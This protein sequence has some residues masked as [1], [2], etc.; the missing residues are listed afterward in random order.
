ME[1]NKRICL[2][3]NIGPHYR[4]PIFEAMDKAFDIDFYFGDHV[5]KPLKVFDYTVLKGFKSI[6]RNKYLRNFYWQKGSVGLVMKPYEYYILDGEPYCLSSWAI[7]LLAKLKR[8]KVIAWTH[9]FYGR[10]G[11]LKRI[12][13]KC[14]YSLFYKLLVYNNYAINI[15]KNVGIA[16]SKMLCIANSLDSDREHEI[17][18]RLKPTGIYSSHFGNDSPTIIYCGR[19][20][21]SKKLHQ[22]VDAVALLKEQGVTVNMVFVGKDDEGVGVEEY[23]SAYGLAAQTWMYGPCYDDEKLG[24][25]FYNAAACVSPG[26]V[27]LTAIHA[28]TFGCPVITHND[29]P[30]QGPE[31]EAITPGVTGDFFSRDNVEELSKKIKTWCSADSSKRNY[32]REAAYKTIDSKWNIHYQRNIIS[33]LLAKE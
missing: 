29:Y 30:Y 11:K 3:A 12:I 22:I 31:F 6:L 8:K 19:I 17:R 20:Q 33:T 21:K 7:L 28:L 23:A 32:T 26:N 27:G 2:I 15:M 9:G 13:K 24:E 18:L 5:E 1:Q 10:E 16:E 25:L 14:F 4:R